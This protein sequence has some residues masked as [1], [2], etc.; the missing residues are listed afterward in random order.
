MAGSAV[1]AARGAPVVVAVGGASIVGSWLVS[2]PQP[3]GST[4][5]AVQNFTA[6]GGTTGQFSSATPMQGV[7]L[8][9]G[10]WQETGAG[11]VA[12]SFR[13][14]LYDAATGAVIGMAL[15]AGNLTVD[16]SGAAWSGPSRIRF[17][18]ADGALQSQTPVTT[19]RATRIQLEPLA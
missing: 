2:V 19:V 13:A 17:F 8:A 18:D 4:F 3:D 9:A 11:T 12:M 7:S 6:D 10:V 1:A 15:A 5:V 16:P 14:P